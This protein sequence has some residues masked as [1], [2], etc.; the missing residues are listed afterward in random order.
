MDN[1]IIKDGF[2]SMDFTR[3]TDMLS[4]A[5]WSPGIKIDEVKKG[6]LNSALVVGA[7]VGSGVQVGYARVI[8]DKTRF[9]YICDVMVEEN[10]RRK[11]I[12]QMLVNHI[13]ANKE[14]E[15]V[16]QWLLITKDAHG[17]YKKSGFGPVSRP[18]GWMEIR[19]R[20]P[21]R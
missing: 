5:F 21:E 15:D 17:V 20:R 11:G 6:A 19:Q 3:V 8:S 18:E 14:L 16:Y 7:F 2:G 1:I 12:G 4:K 9:A 10:Y 13:L